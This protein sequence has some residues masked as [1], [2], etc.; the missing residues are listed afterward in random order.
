VSPVP[1]YR[2]CLENEDD[3]TEAARETRLADDDEALAHANA[4]LGEFEIVKV[5]ERDRFRRPGD[6]LA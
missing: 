2:F 5:W 6:A 4:L 1:L 3:R